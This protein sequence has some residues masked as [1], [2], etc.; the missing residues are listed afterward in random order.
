MSAET[1]RLK[2]N[3]AM[4]L[5]PTHVPPSA[6]IGH[7]PFAFWLVEEARPR[8]L[9]EL[10]SHHGTS[11]LGF[12]QA[13]RHCALDTR[14][15]A[16]DMWTG[17]E[18]SGFYGEDVFRALSQYNQAHYGGFSTLMRM[19]FDEALEYFADGS[20]D[21]LHIDGLHT[22]EAVKHDFE[23]WLP[24]LSPRG[25]ALFHDTMVRERG[26]GVWKL[27]A[28][29]IG[30]YPGFE[31]Q[32]AHGLGV[33]LVGPEQPQALRELAALR[34]SD[35]EAATLR[36][37]DALGG[38]LY[39]AGDPALRE[40]IG[41]LEGELASLRG[42]L[43]AAL[44]ARL[45]QAREEIAA[46]WADR[47]SVAQDETAA[48]WSRLVVV[49]REETAARLSVQVR[50]IHAQ[51]AAEWS[52]RLEAVE[53]GFAAERLR[54]SEEAEARH[55]ELADALAASERIAQDRDAAIASLSEQN[56]T[57]T[58]ELEAQENRLG[59]RE[60]TIE[61]Q[62]ARLRALSAEIEAWAAQVETLNAR[63]AEIE[64]STSWKLTAPVRRLVTALRGGKAGE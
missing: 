22:Y 4:S 35:A 10:G 6:W 57:Q 62:T 13:V 9:V 30:R 14:C 45:A 21:V 41:A 17:D 19:R 25:V 5:A 15:F 2:L 55:A 48:H 27:W 31:F 34:G 8:L 28:E 44:E 52:Q 20:I 40:R 1:L 38:R 59:E 46:G 12:C 32:H 56:R 53:A 3:A 37:F 11:Y 18:H 33:L 7:L 49:A 43:D 54:L 64:T 24:K 42:D 36:L 39:P 23:S 63:L 29:L 16:V 50:E 26:F 58:Q 47:V 60:R 61:D 51:V